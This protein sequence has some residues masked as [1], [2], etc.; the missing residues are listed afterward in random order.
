[1]LG[2]VGAIGSDGAADDPGGPANQVAR[3]ARAGAGVPADAVAQA[4]VL[5]EVARKP[6]ISP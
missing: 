5:V 2:E 1:M 4:A 3:R 6:S